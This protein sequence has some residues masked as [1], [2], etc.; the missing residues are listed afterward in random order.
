MLRSMPIYY[1]IASHLI[2]S[3]RINSFA[4]ETWLA[5][6]EKGGD[7][8]P[9]SN[10]QINVCTALVSDVVP[11]RSDFSDGKTIDHCDL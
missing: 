9:N 8:E 6:M 10:T 2:A 1:R 5:S 7:R 11:S 3:H 4:Q